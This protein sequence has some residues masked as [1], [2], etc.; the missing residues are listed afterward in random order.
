MA[1]LLISVLLGIIFF[2]GGLAQKTDEVSQKYLPFY[3]KYQKIQDV[4]KRIFVSRLKKL[5]VTREILKQNPEL[6]K[7]IEEKFEKNVL[8]KI[9]LYRKPK[10]CLKENFRCQK[11]E[12]FFEDEKGC[13]CR[14]VYSNLYISD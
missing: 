10:Q 8:G 14:E 11:D 13:G 9:Y 2:Y 4:K 3:S 6:K 5:G 1:S 7:Q 12:V